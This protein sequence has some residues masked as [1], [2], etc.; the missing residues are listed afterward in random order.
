ML[1]W[2]LCRLVL[3][4]PLFDRLLISD[5]Q[6]FLDAEGDNLVYMIVIELLE[7]DAL[8]GRM[9]LFAQVIAVGYRWKEA[10]SGRNERRRP[11][12][13]EGAAIAKENC[14]W[15]SWYVQDLYT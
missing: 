7:P 13:K 14:S 5:R 1:F 10:A 6:I 3:Y 4:G 15:L 8:G 11:H 2:G 12:I 9:S